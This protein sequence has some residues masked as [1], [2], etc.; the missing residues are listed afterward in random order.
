MEAAKERNLPR[1]I[2]INK[3]DLPE[4]DLPN[5]GRADPGDLRP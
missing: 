3:I 1:A 5:A 4:L 2:I